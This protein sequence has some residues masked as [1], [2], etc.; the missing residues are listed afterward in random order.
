MRHLTQKAECVRAVAFLPDGRLLSA[1][2]KKAVTVWDPASGAVLDTVRTRMF[3]FALAVS[4]NGQ[5]FA[6]AGRGPPSAAESEILV[7]HLTD[8]NGGLTYY[9]PIERPGSPHSIWSM[10]YTADGEY[11]IAAR[12]RMGGGNMYDG[13]DCRWWHRPKVFESGNLSLSP[14]GFAVTAARTGTK[15]AVTA[16]SQVLVYDHPERPAAS[17][18]PFKN[19]WASAVAFHPNGTSVLAGTGR[20]V[21]STDRVTRTGWPTLLKTEVRAIRAVAV[22]PDGKTLAVGGALGR[23][24]LLDLETRV[25]RLTYS[26][27]I[28]S[29][30]S[31]AYSA[32]GLT[33]AVGAEKGLCLVDV[34]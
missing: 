19:E 12:L 24:S 10:A 31:L 3:V 20:F 13:E 1:A 14:R 32:D 18:H 7:R 16:R 33:L 2:G 5:E 25:E 28:G 9:W 34:E 22:S 4:P 8:P 17:T 27:D 6:A 11:L 15:F 26:F 29:V 30:H 23:I 21:V